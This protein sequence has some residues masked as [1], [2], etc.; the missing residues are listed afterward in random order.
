MS[1]SHQTFEL[2]LSGDTA[3]RQFT[4]FVP[5]GDG[6]RA[7]EHTFEW[8]PDS[9]ALA[10]EL[11]ALAR[12]ATAHEPPADNL[13]VRFGQRL[14]NTVFAGAVRKLWQT[15]RKQARRQPLR[16]AL[17]VDAHTARPL[18]NLPWEYLHDDT[19][20]LALD[21]RTP[22]SRLPW[23]LDAEP[24]E[25]LTEPLRLLVLIAAPLELGPDQVLNTG[26]EVDL[27]LTATQAAR[28]TGQLHLEFTRAG[29]LE[30][31]AHSLQE[32]DPHILHF[33]GH[34]VFNPV[35]DRGYLLMETA[36]GRPRRVPNGEFASLLAQ[37]AQSLRLVFLAACQSAVAP[38]TQGFVD[39]GPALLAADLPAVVAMQHS[40]FNRSAM[41]FGSA[42]YQELAAGAPLDQAVTTARG[43]LAQNQGRTVDFATPVLFLADPGCLRVD[44]AARQ[45]QAAETPV[46]L[47]GVT[48]AQRFVG[49]SAELRTLQT[50]LDPARGPWRAAIIH[51]LGGMGKTVLAARLAQRMAPRLDGVV[52]LRMTPTTTAQIVLDKLGAFLLVHNARFNRAAI[53]QFNQ[54]KDAALPLETKAGLL[55]D[56]L[57]S[58]RL[59]LVF[60]NYED[61]LPAGR[62]VST[63]VE[64]ARTPPEEA[65]APA[66]A[67][68]PA[69][70]K[71]V[72]LLVGGVPGPSRFVFTSRVAFEPL[73][74]G[75]LSGEIGRLDLGEMGFR[76]A[77]YL[78]ET[79]PPLEALPVALAQD[80]RPGAP[81]APAGLSMR[82]V[83]RQVGG[84]P[85]TLNLFARHARETSVGAVL[86]D[87]RGVQKE[88]LEFT[89][90]ERAVAA[91]PPRAADLLRRAT[92][93]AEAVPV[94]GLAY[95]LGDAQDAMPDVGA[96][97]AALLRW[98]LLA[99]PPGT[100]A[101]EA[102]SL[103][104]D[105]ARAQQEPEVRQDLLRR[106]AQYWQGVGRDATSLNPAL[107]ARHYLFLAGDYAAADD[108]VQFAWQYLLRWGQIELLLGLLQESV[109]T[110]AGNRRA[111][112]LGNLATVYQGLGD[113][114]T[115]RRIHEQVLAEFEAGGAP[116]QVA[117]VLHLLG[118]L[119][120]LQ[121]EYPAARGR[122]EQSLAILEELGDRAGVARSLHQLGMLHQ[123]QGEYPAARGRY[124]QSLAIEEELGNRAGVASS[125]HQLGMLH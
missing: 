125:L 38:S 115:A 26:R 68:D 108:I 44:A 59:L 52:S 97:V 25:P 12:A 54:V 28:K 84:H 89:L 42:F 18:R 36:E 8:R 22:F 55:A 112:A 4:A 88:L 10:M 62:A 86:A 24:F 82:Q 20:F 90:L 53:P 116:H 106:A 92:V 39:L 41:D 101:Y 63:A 98:G 16:L 15:R 45:A 61:V 118:N 72:A 114:A 32:F 31:L 35:Q 100:D 13:H 21:W 78:M 75:R 119:H 43:H 77:V 79:L 2:I 46:D 103:V 74:A 110:L 104:K 37:R 113:Y 14:F 117:A 111:V 11:G 5:D 71:L 50:R 57:R 27:I 1:T 65:A 69:L 66:P 23:G 105:W 60:D 94:E 81:P 7:A 120:Y 29:S 85:Y 19:G 91:L 33:T 123:A 17:R 87:L 64:R 80:N 95:L 73:E 102:H 49:R 40:V 47:S 9:T 58:L 34:G 124:E 51:G 93:Y 122:Y 121:G 83:Y 99:Q 48:P 96:E 67:L 3:P 6:G 107:H 70:P 76:D 109:A 30:E 56:I